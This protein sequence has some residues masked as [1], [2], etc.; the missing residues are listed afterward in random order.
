MLN[1]IVSYFL[2]LQSINTEGKNKQAM[3]QIRESPIY[4][5]NLIYITYSRGPKGALPPVVLTSRLPQLRFSER[6]SRD[7]TSPS[8]LTRPGFHP[9]PFNKC[10]EWNLRAKTAEA[11]QKRVPSRLSSG[12]YWLRWMKKE[13]RGASPLTKIGRT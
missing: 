10:T 6:L 4:K 3:S 13:P 11:K 5:T 7:G 12:T 2:T 9:L 8:L 1:G